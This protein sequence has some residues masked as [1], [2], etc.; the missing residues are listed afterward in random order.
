M[1]KSPDVLLQQLLQH[2]MRLEQKV[3]QDASDSDEWLAILDEREKLIEQMQQMGMDDTTITESN[4]DILRQVHEINQRLVSKMDDRKGA[5][6]TQLNNIQR[7]KQAMD[8]Y[9]ENGPNA[10]GAFLDHKK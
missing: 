9:N 4:L 5:V 6:Q 1:E 10:Y 2:T 7:S 8:T 3:L